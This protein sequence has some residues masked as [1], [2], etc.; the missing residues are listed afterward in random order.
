MS[1]QEFMKELEAL[2]AELPTEEREEAVRYYDAYFED[3]GAENEQ[4]VIGELGSAERVAAQLLRDFKA[5]KEVGVY[6]E[7]GYQD[8]EEKKEI[9]VKY[10]AESTASKKGSVSENRQQEATTDGSGIYISRKGMSAGALILCLIVA[11][12][13]FPVWFPLLMALLGVMFGVLLTLAMLSFGIGIGGLACAFA[14]VILLIVGFVK[15]AAVPIVG[16]VFLAAALLV[17]GVGCLLL[18]LA[19]A[20]LKLFV[21]ITGGCLRLCSRIFHGRREAAV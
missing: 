4:V 11:V 14:G 9:P 5:E 16:L 2:L 15:L 7:K 10:E 8:G 20:V 21:W 13:T 19:G 1:K 17:F 6:T 18:L 3:A 12:F